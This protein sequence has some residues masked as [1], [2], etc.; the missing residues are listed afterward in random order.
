MKVDTRMAKRPPLHRRGAVRGEIVEDD[1]DV[2]GRFD[3]RFDLAKKGHEVLRP[4]LGLASCG[5]LAGGHIER[6]EQ[7]QGAM[8]HVVV[9][10]SLGLAEVHRQDRL[11]AL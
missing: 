11:R 6:G 9:R 1:V 8:A 5:H 10:P 2:E 3:V 4:M 7:I